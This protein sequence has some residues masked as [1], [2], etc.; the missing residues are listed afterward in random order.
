MDLG[1]VTL[2]KAME[3][4]AMKWNE[5]STFNKVGS[6]AVIL[7]SVLIIIFAMLQLLGIWENAVLAYMPLACVN[8][9]FFTVS[10]WK[11]NRGTAVFNLVAA[12]FVLLCTV[13]IVFVK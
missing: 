7:C 13:V 6:V 4:S 8:M 11:T 3:V 5:K 10:Y 12:V 2:V 9:L 1:A